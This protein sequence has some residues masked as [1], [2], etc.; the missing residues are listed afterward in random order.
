[1]NSAALR[2]L[3][4]SSRCTEAKTEV[5]QE[6]EDHAEVD[7]DFKFSCAQPLAGTKVSFGLAKAYPSITSAK[8][9]VVAGGG[10]TG[11]EI[12]AD[13]GSVTIPR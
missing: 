5:E 10:S 6:E 9:Q 12:K 2:S 4:G 7:G 3:A 8:V 11:A 1:M 13:R